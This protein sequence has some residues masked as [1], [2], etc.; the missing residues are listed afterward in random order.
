MASSNPQFLLDDQTDDDEDFFDKLVD[1]S[2]SPTQAQA[3]AQAAASSATN[4]LKFD[5]GDGIDSDDAAKA[6]A[7]LSLGDG[8]AQL[9]ESANPGSD[10]AI[11]GPI[12]SLGKE[13]TS[14][15]PVE[16]ADANKLGDDVVV[17]SEDEPLLSETV[18][19]R[20]GSGSPVVKEVDWGSFYADS[21]ANGGGGF[22]SYSDF[23][24][25]LEGSS[26]TGERLR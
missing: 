9:N 15:V 12:S 4:E 19:E 20:D 21:S 1:D 8:D 14:P 17:R 13:E 26:S 11:E 18:K 23:F 24:T 22:G 3:Q 25:E 7:D 10:V 6:F 2:Y 5:N 16:E